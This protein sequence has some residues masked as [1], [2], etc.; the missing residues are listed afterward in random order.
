MFGLN[1]N[2][3]RLSPVTGFYARRNEPLVLHKGE[4]VLIS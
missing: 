1:F 3:R 4:L 2:W